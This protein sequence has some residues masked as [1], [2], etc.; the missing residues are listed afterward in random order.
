MNPFASWSGISWECF[1]LGYD[2]L[3]W[4]DADYE[5]VPD[6]ATS[7]ETSEDGKTWT[8]HIREGMKWQD[9]RA[10]HRAR[11]RLHLQPHPRHAALGLHPVPDRR[12]RRHGAG[13]RHAWSSPRARPTPAC[14][15]STSRSCPST[16]G[17]RSTP[18]TS[19]RSRTCRSSGSGPFRVAELEKS[20]WVKLEANPDY[21][22]GARRPADA[23]RGVLRHQPEHRLDDRG[24]Q[25]RQPRRH[26][27]LPGHLREGPRRGAGH[28]DGGRPGGRLPRAG[29]QLLEEPEEQGEPAPAR[30]GRSAR[31][32]TGPSTSRRSWRRPWPAWPSPARR[33]SRTA[34]GDWHW[35]V[36]EAGQYR[37]DPTR[38]K[39]I[40][41]DAGYCGPRRRRRARGRRR[42]RAL[43]P[44]RRPQ[45]VPRGPG[46]G[47]DDRELVPRRRHRAPARP[48]GRG[49]VQ[50]RGLRQR[51]LRPV[52]LEL[53]RRHRPGVHA[54]HLH[55]ARR[56]AAG[57]TASTRTPS[58]T[59]STSRQAQALDPADPERHR[60]GAR[61]SPTRCRRSCTGTTPTSSSGTT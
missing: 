30:P 31:P 9:G 1:R 34:Q 22:R 2:F 25:G 55:H 20:K 24:L 61:R 33:S 16:S 53:G 50:R 29:L 35:E 40:L 8:F 49:R 54:E 17:R 41:E 21:P 56:S 23:R 28:D 5:P 57:A 58:T 15:R 38:A 14:S 43:V 18:T 60:R 44:S 48:E 10:A 42:R 46:R 32:C 4:Y 36:P 13:R 59:G 51:R 26:R 11:R 52:H 7:W 6:V 27:R 39:Q 37:Y 47:Q 3:T 19:T 45:R 12:H